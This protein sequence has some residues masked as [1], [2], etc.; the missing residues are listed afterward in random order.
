M[1]FGQE[2]I[3]KLQRHLQRGRLSR[4]RASQ[5]DTLNVNTLVARSAPAR[6]QSRPRTGTRHPRAASATRLQ[7]RKP[8]AHPG[9]SWRACQ[10]GHA[11]RAAAWARRS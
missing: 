1:H 2:R 3:T 7:L 11:V 4:R 6:P 10:Q 9:A 8:R 5:K